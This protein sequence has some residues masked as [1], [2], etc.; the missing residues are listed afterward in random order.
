MRE[1]PDH[2]SS[3]RLKLRGHHAGMRLDREGVTSLF[4][5]HAS[6]LGATDVRRVRG[7]PST[8]R[9]SIE[10]PDKQV[11]WPQEALVLVRSSDYWKKRVHLQKHELTMLLVWRHDSIVP[12]PVLSLCDGHWHAARTNTKTHAARNR[13]T[14]SLLLGELLCGNQRAYD[15]LEQLPASTRYRYLKRVHAL[16]HRERG[17]PLAV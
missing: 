2:R 4:L 1:A 14:A 9:F 5:Q 17:R 15:E 13:Y 16:M 6:A 8:L 10:D 12:L 7:A 3:S 11:M